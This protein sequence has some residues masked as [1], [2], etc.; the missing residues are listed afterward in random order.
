MRAAET[1]GRSAAASVTSDAPIKNPRVAARIVE[2]EALVVVIDQKQLHA[3]NRVGTRVWELCDG[4]SVDE[5]A[6]VLVAEFEVE[7]DTAQRDVRDFV[8]ELREAGALMP[9]ETST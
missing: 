6:E 7:G 1:Q 2:E 3:L 9:Q 8:R 4:R 5:I